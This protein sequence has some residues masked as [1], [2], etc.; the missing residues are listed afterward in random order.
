MLRIDDVTLPLTM[1]S[2]PGYII[3]I[4]HIKHSYFRTIYSTLIQSLNT[5][6]VA[7]NHY[8]HT[9]H[10]YK[11]IPHSNVTRHSVDVFRVTRRSSV[12]S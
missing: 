6:S 5:L 7:Y 2:P 8:Y 11:V 4:K 1:L 3:Y 12:S 9:V 10:F